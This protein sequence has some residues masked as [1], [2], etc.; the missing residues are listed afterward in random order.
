MPLRNEPRVNPDRYTP[1][2]RRAGPSRLSTWSGRRMASLWIAWPA[3]VLLLCLVGAAMSVLVQH[4]LTEIRADITRSNLIG[5]ALAAL[6]PPLC[7]TGVWWRMR[8]RRR[9]SMSD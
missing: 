2:E 1:P 4:S 5:L 8:H 6:L 3:S 7:L 9:T